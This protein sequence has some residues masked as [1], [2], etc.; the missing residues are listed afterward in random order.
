MIQLKY[1]QD[2]VLAMFFQD[3]GTLNPTTAQIQKFDADLFK[4]DESI[5][6]EQ[7]TAAGLNPGDLTA[8]S[9]ILLYSRTSGG[10]SI[11]AQVRQACRFF[12]NTDGL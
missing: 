5:L 6:V 9:K 7:M 10:G 4:A 1:K 3:V 11:A 2:A 8:K 12:K